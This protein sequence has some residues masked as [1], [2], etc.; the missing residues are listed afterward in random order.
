MLPC[1]RLILLALEVTTGCKQ[2]MARFYQWRALGFSLNCC[3][4]CSGPASL[5]PGAAGPEVC[6]LLEIPLWR[7]QPSSSYPFTPP[8]QLHFKDLI[9]AAAFSGLRFLPPL[10]CI[11]SPS[12]S[13]LI[14]DWTDVIL[15]QKTVFF[16]LSWR[17]GRRA[18][19][20]WRI[21]VKR[22]LN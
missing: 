9:T 5:P 17:T 11:T 22:R 2:Q 21:P 16:L 7:P 4:V 19:S 20:R 1:A 15:R 3:I 13:D 14:T 10:F 6:E 12:H 18:A 8:A